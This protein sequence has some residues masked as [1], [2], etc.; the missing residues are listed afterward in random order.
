MKRTA[1]L[2]SLSGDSGTTGRCGFAKMSIPATRKRL[3][4]LGVAASL[5][6]SSISLAGWFWCCC[7]GLCSGRTHCSRSRPPDPR[8]RSPWP[9]ASPPSTEHWAEKSSLISAVL[10]ELTAESTDSPVVVA[11]AEAATLWLQKHCPAAA[12]HSS[13]AWRTRWPPAV[14]VWGPRD[15]MPKR[16]SAKLGP[17]ANSRP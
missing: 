15:N 1:S 12:R 5:H 4:S 9:P 8:S 17:Q 14:L 16:L 7:S 2:R 11:V 10:A 13:C 3:D 6:G